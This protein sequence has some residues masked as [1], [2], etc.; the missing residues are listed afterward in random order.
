MPAAA[1]RRRFTPAEF[2]EWELRQEERHEYHRGEVS[3]MAGGTEQHARLISNALF[4]LRLALRGGD[5]F[6]YPDALGVRVEAEDLFTYPDLSVVCGEPQFFDANRTRLLNPTVLV[7][8]L[9]PSTGDYDRTATARFYRR[10][11]SLQAYVLL[12]HDVPAVDVLTPD[13]DG[14]HLA[15][16]RDGRAEIRPLGVALDLAALYDGV[17]FPDTPGRPAPRP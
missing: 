5:C 3:L 17:V 11:P 6:V 13:G 4:E 15:P 7:E 12:S 14:W 8:A 1:A 10:V 2:V 16:D 9:S